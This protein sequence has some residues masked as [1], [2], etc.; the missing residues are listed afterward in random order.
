[1]RRNSG[2]I[3]PLKE[4]DKSSASGNFDT[5]DNYNSRLNDKWPIKD[6][7]TCTTTASSFNRNDI[8]TWTYNGSLD[9]GRMFYVKYRTVSGTFA[10]YTQMNTSYLTA[11]S[12]FSRSFSGGTKQFQMQFYPTNTSAGAFSFYLTLHLDSPDNPEIYTS[13]TITI[14]DQSLSVSVPASTNQSSSM[15]MTFTT[16]GA[17]NGSTIYW[18]LDS[19]WN[20]S[21]GTVTVNNNS[22]TATATP[23]PT[24]YATTGTIST[25]AT[26][27]LSSTSTSGSA[28]TFT[29]VINKEYITPELRIQVN[30]GT[31]YPYNASNLAVNEGD[32]IRVYLTAIGGG[33]VGAIYNNQVGIGLQASNPALNT[34]DVTQGTLNA[35]L[36][37]ANSYSVTY[38]L[39]NDFA[40]EGTEYIQWLAT[41]A[42]NS[43]TI[44][45][46]RQLQV[47]DTSVPPQ[48]NT[49]YPLFEGSSYMYYDPAVGPT[50]VLA[51]TE[52]ASFNIIGTM[53]VS[54]T[55][56]YAW[57]IN[58]ITTVAADFSATSGTVTASGNRLAIP[59][60]PVADATTEYD[61]TFTVTVTYNGAAV[62]NGTTPP[63]R[64]RDTSKGANAVYIDVTTAANAKY[65]TSG[66]WNTN[67]SSNDGGYMYYH[68]TMYSSTPVA[69]SAFRYD[70]YHDMYYVNGSSLAW[71][72]NQVYSNN[73]Y[74]HMFNFSR[75]GM[76]GISWNGNTLYRYVYGSAYPTS[77][78]SPNNTYS[79]TSTYGT[80]FFAKPHFSGDGTRMYLTYYSAGNA[81]KSDGWYTDHYTLTT[82]YDPSNKTL[83]GTWIRPSASA[84]LYPE[85][86]ATKTSFTPGYIYERGHFEF[87]ATGTKIIAMHPTDRWS[88]KMYT[89]TTAWDLTTATES[90]DQSMLKAF[91]TNTSP[92]SQNWFNYTNT[93]PNYV[94]NAGIKNFTV[95]PDGLQLWV[96]LIDS[97]GYQSGSRYTYKFDITA[98]YVVPKL[99]I[100]KGDISNISSTAQASYWNIYAPSNNAGSFPVARTSLTAN[101]T[102]L[103]FNSGTYS[104]TTAN[105]NNQIIGAT[106]SNTTSGA[107]FTSDGTRAINYNGSGGLNSSNSISIYSCPT[108]WSLTGATAT[109]T[110]SWTPNNENWNGPQGSIS[111]P[112]IKQIYISD[113]GNQVLMT[114]YNANNSGSGSGAIY[115]IT[116]RMNQAWTLPNQISQA[117]QWTPATF[118]NSAPQNNSMDWFELSP[119]KK[120]I[121]FWE[122]TTYDTLRQV[123]WAYEWGVQYGNNYYN[124]GIT[125]SVGSRGYSPLYVPLWNYDGTKFFIVE[126]ANAQNYNKFVRNHVVTLQELPYPETLSD[127]VFM[128]PTSSSA[129]GQTITLAYKTSSNAGTKLAESVT[130]YKDYFKDSSGQNY[131][132]SVGYIVSPFVTTSLTSVGTTTSSNAYTVAFSDSIQSPYT[133][134]SETDVTPYC[135][136]ITIS[137]L[138]YNAANADMSPMEIVDGTTYKIFLENGKMIVTCKST[139]AAAK[140]TAFMRSL[141][142]IGNAASRCEFYSGSPNPNP[143]KYVT[144]NIT[145]IVRN[146]VKVEITGTTVY[147][148]SSTYSTDG[149]SIWAQYGEAYSYVAPPV[150]MN[151]MTAT[152]IGYN[153]NVGTN[154]I[155]F[156]STEVVSKFNTV[157]MSVY[158]NNTASG[159]SPSYPWDPY[160]PTT[161]EMVYQVFN[162]TP[163]L[164]SLS[165]GTYNQF[166]TTSGT[167][168]LI[169]NAYPQSIDGFWR[170]TYNTAYFTLFMNNLALTKSLSRQSSTTI[171]IYLDYFGLNSSANHFTLPDTWKNNCAEFMF[172]DNSD[173][174]IYVL[175]GI[176]DAILTTNSPSQCYIDII[177][178][179]TQ[180]EY[181]GNG[182][183][184]LFTKF[185]YK[186]PVATGGAAYPVT[187]FSTNG[188]N[189]SS[190]VYSAS[191]IN[192]YFSNSA[193]TVALWNSLQSPG[194]ANMVFKEMA[195]PPYGTVWNLMVT[196]PPSP[197]Y[198][199]SSGGPYGGGAMRL[200]FGAQPSPQA[201]WSGPG[202]TIQ[203]V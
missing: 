23:I 92:G 152:G 108:P 24:Y 124:Q 180:L 175:S 129:V 64:L 62:T 70:Y 133:Y 41:S 189:G 2:L 161:S 78:V 26:A 18:Y 199:T 61:Q 114:V 93:D 51:T 85:G 3:G 136:L 21:S 6:W 59:I 19:N 67:I 58:H 39:T 79:V 160:P 33:T 17:T 202:Q 157:I 159:T 44:A 125:K 203:K 11:G 36:T 177:G 117:S 164:V 35:A 130:A 173:N 118:R 84:I 88:F 150:P 158:G 30:G 148:V 171:R 32:T 60:S 197:M 25:S 72:Q 182:Y 170:T 43:A 168:K 16:V 115:M 200:N 22:A 65:T 135:T 55:N 8:I 154:S 139:T 95:S 5:F 57:T 109:S 80:S 142:M 76:Y 194:S 75:D 187:S 121:V 7:M 155:T 68:P 149:I 122:S 185:A 13:S 166:G 165:G 100:G 134:T 97:S 111:F 38:N 116:F 42:Y 49:W 120:R 48:V 106:N 73:T 90:G 201:A 132:F 169:S 87:N 176:T 29:P 140:L 183:N 110:V 1:M 147:T 181:N 191:Y 198:Y 196:T 192:L 127:S 91:S 63:I 123:T 9:A 126:S 77:Y 128:V 179:I 81:G 131:F 153:P 174:Y 163:Y 15:T 145:D 184:T 167:D 14:A 144:T 102:T 66:D 40:L 82:A 188:S 34:S 46:S 10:P 89:L 27:Y 138:Q 47:A 103:V 28:K 69:M 104:L 151:Y 143:G 94:I 96:Q 53:A 195:N 50:P 86:S 141:I 190:D 113:T 156:T 56:T 31:S 99:Y 107:R 146:D 101:E 71:G 20:P 74:G 178:T 112:M 52:S 54:N 98:E 162:G 12:I 37:S 172:I 193:D 45:T 186:W 83:V 4:A 119:N 137:R 105:Q